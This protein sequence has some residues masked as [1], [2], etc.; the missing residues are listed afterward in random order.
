MSTPLSSLRPPDDNREIELIRSLVEKTRQAKIPWVK[1]ATAIT[2]VIP[3][4][5]QINFVLSSL[6]F[7]TPYKGWIC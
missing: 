3:G 2:A 6:M 7:L 1:Q 5:V 4:G